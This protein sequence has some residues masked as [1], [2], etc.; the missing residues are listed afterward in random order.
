MR[1]TGRPGN[2]P[3]LERLKDDWLKVPYYPDE[4]LFGGEVF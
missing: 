1:K 3:D 2:M 4:D